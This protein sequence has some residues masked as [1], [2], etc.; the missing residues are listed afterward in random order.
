MDEIRK[1]YINEKGYNVVEPLECEWWKLSLTDVSVKE[2]LRESFPNKPPLHLDR[3]LDKI[4]PGTL[5][6][7][8]QCDI[9]V[10]ENVRV[11]LQNCRHFLRV[12]TYLDK[13]LDQYCRTI[14]EK[15]RIMTQLRQLL[16][17]SFELTRRRDNTPLLLFYLELG[18]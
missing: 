10:P 11:H 8:V 9:K 7:Y 2:H 17:S 5:F 18:H 15:K 1:Q 12:Q 13:M 6:G 16:I 14:A 3:L 4:Q